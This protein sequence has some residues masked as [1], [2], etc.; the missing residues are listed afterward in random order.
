MYPMLA[1]VLGQMGRIG[2]PGA[3]RAYFRGG[4]S[5]PTAY[6]DSD[7]GRKGNGK[8]SEAGGD[9]A[10][11]RSGGINS[12][13]VTTAE[14]MSKHVAVEMDGN[15]RWTK[16][17]GLQPWDGHRAGVEALR[18]LRFSRVYLLLCGTHLVP[19]IPADRD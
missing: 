19:N 2:D 3:L 16:N 8:D 6:S 10:V 18:A 1:S 17:Q 15:G 13:G 12:S 14:L 4:Q 7:T 9:G 11:Y 5:L